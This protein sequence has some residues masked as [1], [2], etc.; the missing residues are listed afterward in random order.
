MA[1]LS[2]LQGNL[3]HARAAHLLRR[4]SF[5]YSKARIDSFA[6]KTAD[7]AVNLLL[8][9]PTLQLTQPVYDNPSTTTVESVY[10]INPPGQALPDSESNLQR[11]VIGW[12]LNE[13]LRD[14]GMQ[15]KMMLF[16]HQ[17]MA[18]SMNTTAH[19]VVFDYMSLLRWGALGNFKKLAT[20]MIIDN[21]ML[22]YLNN[23]VNT[24]TNPNENFAREFLELFTIGKGPQAGPGDYTNYTE[25]DIVQAAKVLTGFVTRTQRDQPDPETGIPRGTVTFSR[26]DTTNK[27]FSHRF[28]NTVI[29]GATNSTT[30]WNEINAFVD[31]VFNQEETA[32]NFCRRLYRYFVHRN[33]TPEIENDI[34]A[35]LATHFRNNNFEVAPTLHKL[36]SSQHFFDADDSDNA[37]E[38]VGGMIKS[39][40]ELALQ[41]LS[42]FGITI[43]DPITQNNAHYNQ[44]WAAG[45]MDRMLGYANFPLFFPQ[46]VAGYPAYH[47]EPDY[48]RQ[49]FNSATIVARYKLPQMLLSGK[50]V[51]GSSPNSSIAVKLNIAP[52]VRDSGFCADPSDP[53]VLVQD[54]LRYMLPAEVD[55]DRFSYFY[56]DVFLDHLPPAD[57]TYEWQ[58]YL[59]TGSE[60]E[61]K[62]ALERLIT[63]IMFSPEYQTF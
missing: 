57:W 12:W 37:D 3:G 13:A 60:T 38:I 56:I 62:I 58:N 29:T 7:Q 44:F 42:F 23:N 16:F 6:N 51:L 61:V 20:K 43:P 8:T 14:Q 54:L 49:W 48:S 25:D 15:H 50:R 2:A 46:D 59:A 40:L 17:Y 22:R 39:P 35:P 32:R 18:T 4:A 5:H 9:P 27:T 45:V 31:M 24:K 36:L 1:S 55:N 21:N 47:Q 52:W 33:I 26:H 10:W 30:F 34:I 41:S 53:Y 11:R 63:Q 28:Q 19:T